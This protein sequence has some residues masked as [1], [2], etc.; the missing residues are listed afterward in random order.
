M[1]CYRDMTFCSFYKECKKKDCGRAMTEEVVKKAGK[2]GIPVYQFMEKPEC[3]EA[4]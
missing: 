1:I 2:I 3:F 4:K